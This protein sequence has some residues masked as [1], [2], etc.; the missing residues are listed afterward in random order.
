MSFFDSLELLTDDPILSLP[1]LF[2]SDLH[3]KKVNL[4]VG[5]Y[6]NEEGKPVVLNSVKKAEAILIE[7]GENKEY[8]P[9]EGDPQFI[10]GALG[11]IFG[12]VKDTVFGAQS[13]GGS[14]ALRIGGEFLASGISNGLIYFSN[15]SWPNHSQIFKKAGLKVGYYPYYDPKT[16]SLDF[17]G[18]REALLKL[19]PVKCRSFTS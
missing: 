1:I 15:P 18:F 17:S 19:S 7:K 6:R 4:G 13:I 8:L 2:K 12:S 11:L 14:G 9:I 5:A 16:H 3:E 10:E